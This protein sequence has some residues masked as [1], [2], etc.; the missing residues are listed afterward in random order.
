MTQQNTHRHRNRSAAGSSERSGRLSQRPG[1]GSTRC[2]RATQQTCASPTAALRIQ[3]YTPAPSIY[4]IHSPTVYVRVCFIQK[5][6]IISYARVFI[7]TLKLAGS[8]AARR[9]GSCLSDELSQPAPPSAAAD[10]RLLSIRRAEPA[11]PALRGS[12]CPAQA[13]GS[14]L[15]DELSQP[16]PPSAAAD[17]RLL[18]IRRAEPAS[19]ALRGSRPPAP[20]YQTS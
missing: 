19:P 20:V 12:C 3:K 15:S 16:A 2:P 10:R 4:G 8:P 6:T 17:R 18:S 13:A 1:P 5:C 11:S 9:A 7:R 14:C